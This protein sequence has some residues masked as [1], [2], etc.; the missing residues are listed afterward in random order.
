VADARP[1]KRVK[2]TV[3]HESGGYQQLTAVP[4]VVT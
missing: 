1:G 4:G 3:R 2:I